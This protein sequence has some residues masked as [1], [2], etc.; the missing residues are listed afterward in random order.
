VQHRARRRPLLVQDGEDVVVGLSVV[1]HQRLVQ[2]VG[3]ADVVPEGLGLADP[4]RLVTEVVQPRLADGDH[5]V[6]AGELGEA[7]QHPVGGLDRVVGVDADR[8]E[9]AVVAGGGARTLRR[10]RQVGPDGDDGGHT[11]GL[12]AFQH[13]LR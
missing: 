3:D 11:G 7:L 9:D 13:R 10:G 1:H 12:G 8:G 5:P 4:R 6:V 2:V